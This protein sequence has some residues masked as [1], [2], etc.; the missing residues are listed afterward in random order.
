MRRKG[1]AW[2]ALLLGLALT[3]TACT[4][5]TKKETGT[6]TPEPAKQE[7]KSPKVLTLGYWSAP[8]S[9]NTIT[10]KTQYGTIV[11]GLIYPSLY[12]QT[13]KLDYEPR[14]AESMDKNDKQDTFTF[15]L[16]K[17]AKWSDGKPITADDVAYTYQVIAHP[18][19]PTSRRSLIDTVKGLD[20]NG[21]SETKDFNV[22]G[23]KVLDPYTIQF[24]TKAPVDLDSFMEKVAAGIYIMPKHALEPFVKADLKNLDKADITMKPTVY[25]GPFRLV[26][27]VTDS[28]IE[29]APNPDYFLGA[30]KLDKL[31]IKIVG[32]ST[33]A[34]SIQK[35]EIDVAAGQG[36]GEV[37]I[38]DWDK[39]STDSNL[40]PVT[41]VA[42]SYQYLDF[43]VARPEFSNPKIRQAFAY[44]INRPLIVQRL[45]KGQGEVLNTP[46]NSANK[47]YRK[48]LQS[49]LAYNAQ[50]AKKMLQDNGWDFN[51]EIVLL[52]PTG[53]VVREQS[54][55]IIMA[56]LLEIGVKVKI[57]KVDFATRQARSKAGD[58]QLSLV[59][60]SSTF[61]PDFSAQ[62]SSTGAFN[63]RKYANP[64]F[65]QLLDQGKLIVKF[66]DKKAHYDK[67]QQMFVDELPFLPLYAVKALAVVNKRVIAAKP[68][69]NGLTWNAHLW[70]VK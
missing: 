40:E 35:G 15:H 12:A 25:G 26:Q 3:A 67:L 22:S 28:H 47:Y 6:T 56:N 14:L 11:I 27:Y 20:S 32:A 8:D 17:N 18:D 42:P 2:I 59:G 29:L 69:P 68:G 51:K 39:V 52:T 54:A 30:P 46:I 4:S 23:I 13:D 9:F 61:D 34:A 49:L 66:E 19:T 36:I 38:A 57:E 43:N 31:F 1:S 55:D 37:P 48:D 10:N 45:L 44:A 33:F 21:V 60:F 16:R 65:D 53:N 7:S 58:F 62:V 64:T 24:Q 63:D 41:Y 5:G 50:T 70:D